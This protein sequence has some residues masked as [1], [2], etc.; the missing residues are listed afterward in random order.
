ML[1]AR[2]FPKK[3]LI[4]IFV[5][6]HKNTKVLKSDLLFPI[7]VGSSLSKN[8]YNNMLRDDVGENISSKNPM[9]CE[10]TA[11]YWAWKNQD[12][13]YYGLFHYRR[14]LSFN[15]KINN[16][17][18]SYLYPSSLDDLRLKYGYSEKQIIKYISKYD[19]I[20]PKLDDLC[21][22]DT[23]YDKYK[24]HWFHNIEDLDKVLDII[25]MEYP[26]MYPFALDCMNSPNA[27][28]CN[29]FILKK[30]YFNSYCTWLFNILSK[31][32]QSADM[33]NYSTQQLRVIGYLGERL[34]NIYLH[35]LKQDEKIKFA[36][37]TNLFF[38]DN[39]SQMLDI[40][41]DT[42]IIV[43]KIFSDSSC[44]LVLS[45]NDVYVPYLSSLLFSICENSSHEH[46][47]DI[48]IFN[49]DISQAHQDQ[50]KLCLATYK[51]IYIRFI[52]V[53]K[54][55]NPYK[56]LPTHHHFKI[57]TYFRFFIPDIM[58]DYDKVLYLDSDMIVQEDI[59]NLFQE[60]VDGFC[61]GACK[62]ADSA[63]LY[64]G[65]QP[66]KKTYLDNVLKIKAPYDYF[67]AG[68]ILFNLKEI[69]TSFSIREMLN[70]ASS[71]D[72]ELLDQDVLN[73]FF[74]GKVKFLDMSWNY[75]IDM[76][77]LRKRDIISL[78]NTELY[79][80]Y[81]FSANHPKIIHYA[82][83]EKP[84]NSPNCEFGS[85]FW[86]YCKKT[87]FYEE[88]LLRSLTTYVSK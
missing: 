81:M 33:S 56:N 53:S 37:F 49:V 19:V 30:E 42:P 17:N 5:A 1:K 72:W 57:E 67:Q 51:N 2:S 16:T 54:L 58:P 38:K 79:E 25:K 22:S 70:F 68:T 84:W 14:Y 21:S 45:A 12:A 39:S 13:D 29:M 60:N 66:T 87:S 8:H 78:A 69:R 71:Y 24:A 83:P 59:Y 76:F 34:T 74:Q 88:T 20:A 64:N 44:S 80:K 6:C 4:K 36:E 82:G 32:E 9:Y 26:T 52:N 27:Y 55:L 73:Y 23:L 31:Y 62:D 50:I 7:H 40:I 28:Y 61:L 85:I 10:L 65:Y 15:P 18:I 86:Y 46:N 11:T 47:Y 75:M 48:V 3:P 77:D 35:W 43:P 41:E 63:G